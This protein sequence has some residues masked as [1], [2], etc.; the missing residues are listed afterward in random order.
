M[1]R[2]PH[3]EAEL[4]RELG[5]TSALAIGVG[6]MIAAGIFTLSGLAVRNVG[7]AAIVAFLLAAVVALFTALTYCEFAALYPRSGEGYLYARKT[8][9]AT[10]AWFVGFCLFLGYTSSCGFYISSLSTYFQEFVWHLPW[11]PLSGLVGLFALSL[12]NMKGTKESGSFQ[13]VVTIGKVLL[14]IWFVIGGLQEVTTDLLIEHF[15]KDMGQIAGTSAMVFITFFGFSAIAAS[16]GEVKDPVRNIPRAIF[17]SMGI[18]TV[19]YTLVVMCVLAAGLTSY[20]EASMGEAARRFL[21]PVGGMVIVAGALFS[22]ISASNAS[23]M[24][25]S[26][27]AMA[28]SQLGHLPAVLGK[29]HP[30]TRTPVAALA[31]VGLTIGAFALALDLEDLAHYAD[32]V[33]LLALIGVDLA[34]IVHRRRFPDLER[35]FRVPFVPL[36]PGLGI[37]AN[38]YLMGQLIAHPLPLVLALGTLAIGMG[39]FLVWRRLGDVAV[40]ESPAAPAPIPADDEGYRILVPL[41]NPGTCDALVGLAC[42]L[43]ADAGGEVVAAR[44]VVV[45]EQ[46]GSVAHLDTLRRETQVL[47]RAEQV[48]E[49]LGVHVA[50]VVTIAHDVAR[51]VLSAASDRDADLVLLGWKGYSSTR[52][53]ILGEITDTV[54]SQSQRDIMLVKPVGS[55]PI[56]SLLL[57]TAGGSHAA[58]ATSYAAALARRTNTHITVTTVITPDS[59]AAARQRAEALLQETAALLGDVTGVETRLMEGASVVDTIVEASNDYDAVMIG[60]ARK[61]GYREIL[62]GTIP[63]AIARHSPCTVMV[64]RSAE[65]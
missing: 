15:S 62:F 41:S 16:A 47:T 12:L 43:A 18:V 8:F 6:T 57:P 9:P 38:L 48:G 27:V 19:L 60:A 51:A 23:I 28:M 13:V 5:L 25:G 35:P 4:S 22:M 64:V 52:E 11:A 58:R 63:E 44:V 10:A 21:G 29:V 50:P 30:E 34:L 2:Q 59:D 61:V 36:L 24:A 31:L 53:R 55:E 26:R 45:P 54:V 32:A 20:D 49:R 3:I 14:L 33:L 7:S 42:H 1:D 65:G 39:G 46:L 17:W 56:R 40:T 37:V